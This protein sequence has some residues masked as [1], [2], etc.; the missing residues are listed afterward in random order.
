MIINMLLYTKNSK[1]DLDII[2]RRK[3]ELKSN[4]LFGRFDYYDE[5]FLDQALE[6]CDLIF[7]NN[8]DK[9]YFLKQYLK[10]FEFEYRKKSYSRAKELTKK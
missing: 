6:F 5:V 8:Y 4:S 3:S 7:D 1:F 10:S 9:V 2:E